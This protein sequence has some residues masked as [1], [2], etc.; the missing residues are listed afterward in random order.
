MSII[1]SSIITTYWLIAPTECFCLQLVGMF[2]IYIKS[3]GMDLNQTTF[4]TCVWTI[5]LHLAEGRINAPFCTVYQFLRLHIVL[6]WQEIRDVSRWL[7]VMWHHWAIVMTLCTTNRIFILRQMHFGQCD[8][9]YRDIAYSL[10][11]TMTG[12]F[13]YTNIAHYHTINECD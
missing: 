10:S 4:G 5:N 2:I 13:S 11:I 3:P 6:C 1:Y 7:I 12:I 8:V 9:I